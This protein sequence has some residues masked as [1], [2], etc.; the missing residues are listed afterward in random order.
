M[1][2]LVGSPLTPFNIN[3]SNLD[4]GWKYFGSIQDPIG[5]LFYIYGSVNSDTNSINDV[6]F[7]CNCTA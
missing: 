3:R 4:S 2:G 5:N 7:G 1:T 6:I